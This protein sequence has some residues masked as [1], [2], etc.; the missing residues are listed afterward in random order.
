MAGLRVPAF[1]RGVSFPEAAATDSAAGTRII[2]ARKANSREK[3]FHEQHSLK[4][5][6]MSIRH[7]ESRPVH[8][9]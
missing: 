1:E 2:S 5:R 9:D 4:R 8:F 7:P 3:Q 6:D